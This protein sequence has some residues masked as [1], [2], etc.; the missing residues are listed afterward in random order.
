ME[1]DCNATKQRSS[2]GLIVQSDTVFIMFYDAHRPK[3]IVEGHRKMM[4]KG[5]E[6]SEEC[7]LRRRAFIIREMIRNRM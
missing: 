6:V 2:L 3:N 7:F 4:T 1:L 5:V